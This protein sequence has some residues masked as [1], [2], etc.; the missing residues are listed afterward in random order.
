MAQQTSWHDF[1]V[2]QDQEVSWLQQVRQVSE[3]VVSDASALPIHDEQTGLVTLAG[4]LLG[5]E[6]GGQLVVEEDV[7][8]SVEVNNA[9]GFASPDRLATRNRKRCACESE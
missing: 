2:V 9:C 4:R 3:D 5:D 7:H 1:R 8:G 6:V